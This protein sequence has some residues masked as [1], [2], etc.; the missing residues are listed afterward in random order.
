M[1]KILMVLALVLASCAGAGAGE[2]KDMSVNRGDPTACRTAADVG[3]EVWWTFVPDYDVNRLSL[4]Q[5]PGPFRR[6]SYLY[7]CKDHGKDRN[8]FW[9]EQVPSPDREIP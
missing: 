7:T 5:A 2:G 1:N 8:G 6:F 3:K 4:T 9:W